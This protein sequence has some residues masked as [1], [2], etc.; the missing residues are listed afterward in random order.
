MD[1]GALLWEI[2]SPQG[3]TQYIITID[4]DEWHETG[5]IERDGK[6]HD[7]FEMKLR[8]TAE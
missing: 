2:D 4:G 5:R 3:R 6:W 1:N 8:R 7:F